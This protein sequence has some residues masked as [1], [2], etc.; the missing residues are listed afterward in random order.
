MMRAGFRWNDGVIFREAEIKV[1][2][3]DASAAAGE[4]ATDSND[5]DKEEL[6]D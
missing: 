3:Y 5:D 6:D 1:N 4:Q 2:V